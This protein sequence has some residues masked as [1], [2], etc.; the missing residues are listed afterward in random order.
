MLYVNS[1]GGW[2]PCNRAYVNSGGGWRNVKQIYTNTNGKWWPVWDKANAIMPIY[3]SSMWAGGRGGGMPGTV[4]GS[5]ACYIDWVL[6]IYR[7]ITGMV[8]SF[9][10]SKWQGSLHGS[11]GN[12]SVSEAWPQNTQWRAGDYTG[13]QQS[14]VMAVNPPIWPDGNK[15][16]RLRLWNIGNSNEGDGKTYSWVRLDRVIYGDPP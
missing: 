8:F 5:T 14:P 16:G 4:W 6:E 11:G 15:F 10:I 13:E 2:R 1:G 7:P 9:N 12:F 3:G